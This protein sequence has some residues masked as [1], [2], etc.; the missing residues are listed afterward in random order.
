MSSRQKSPLATADTAFFGADVEQGKQENINDPN[1]LY[2]L[3]KV[4][5]DANSLLVHHASAH[6]SIEERTRPSTKRPA[7]N[8]FSLS[9][10]AVRDFDA[11]VLAG[12]DQAELARMGA[13]FLGGAQPFMIILWCCL[14]F[15]GLGGTFYTSLLSVPNH[16]HSNGDHGV[17]SQSDLST[18][19]QMSQVGLVFWQS[20]VFLLGSGRAFFLAKKKW[21]KAY[22]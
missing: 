9:Q 5:D 20:A 19:F 14:A 4:L 10:V 1:N 3:R 2:R 7:E 21:R 22:W 16:P 8:G 18:A 17:L 15:F 6:K 11:L 12:Q 13:G